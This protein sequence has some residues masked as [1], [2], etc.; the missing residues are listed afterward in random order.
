MSFALAVYFATSSSLS[1][2]EA[3]SAW[4]IEDTLRSPDSIR[5][6][7][8][9]VR[10]SI[11]SAIERSDDNSISQGYHALLDGWSIIAGRTILSLRLPLVLLGML[12]FCVMFALVRAWINQFFSAILWIAILSAIIVFLW[13]STSDWQ[14]LVHRASQVRSITEPILITTSARSPLA[15]HA[16][17]N[18]L[19]DGISIDLSWRDFTSA[20]IATIGQN[21]EDMPIIWGMLDMQTP[22]SWEVLSILLSERGIQYRDNVDGTIFYGFDTNSSDSLSLAFGHTVEQIQ[23]ILVSDFYTQLESSSNDTICILIEIEFTQTDTYRIN[24]QGI[25]NTGEP[26]FEDNYDVEVQSAP[27]LFAENYCFDLP[28]DDYLVRLLVYSNTTPDQPL[29]VIESGHIWGDFIVLG[30]RR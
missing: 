28:D 1:D 25:T 3:N 2:V 7:L 16:E 17:Q 5:E 27:I 20:E 9:Y 12:V 19:T 26:I 13:Q 18:G 21:L 24:L 14:G 11:L 29:S 8:R 6:T 10:D 15:Y 22:Q 4:V 23:A 30:Y